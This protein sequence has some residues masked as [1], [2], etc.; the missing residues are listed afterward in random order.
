M[1]IDQTEKPEI[2]SEFGED[3]HWLCGCGACACHSF[4]GAHA[5]VRNHCDCRGEDFEQ[6]HGYERT[7]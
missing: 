3:H 4:D 2:C 5:G 7:E 6:Y 1:P